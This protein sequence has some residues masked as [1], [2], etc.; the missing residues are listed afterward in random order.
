MNE[1]NFE[2][3]VLSE[4][5]MIEEVYDEE[6][7]D[8]GYCVMKFNEKF[9]YCGFDFGGSLGCFEEYSSLEEL[10]KIVG[11]RGEL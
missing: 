2:D 4:G 3:V 11:L 9:Y 10:R 1:E 5:E 7:N 6:D 8:S